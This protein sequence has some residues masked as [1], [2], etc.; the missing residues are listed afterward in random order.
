MLPPPRSIAT[1]WRTGRSWTAPRKP[2]IAS[3][4][5]S[6]T[7][8]GTPAS[9]ASA[10]GIA[11]RASRTADVATAI[12]RSAPAPSAIARKSRRASRVRSI[13]SG[14]SR[15]SSRNSRPR[16]RG[17]RASS[18]TSRCSPGRS[19]NT[20][21]RAEFE[22]TSTTANGRSSARELVRPCTSG[23]S[24]TRPERPE[25]IGRPRADG[26]AGSRM[27]PDAM[28]TLFLIRHGLTAV[29]GSRLY[30]RTQ[31]HPSRRA[32]PPTGGR[33]RRAVRGR[34]AQRDL[35]E[36]AGTLHRD[37]GATR[38]GP[39]ARDPHLGCADRDGRRRL[40]G[41]N[42]PSLRRTKLWDTVQ[43]SPSRFHFPSGESFVD[44]EARLLDEIE[45]VVARHPRGRV[46][47]GTHGDLV[48]MLSPTTRAPTW[49]SSNE[50]R[51]DPASVSRRASR[52]RD[53]PHPARERHREPSSVRSG[54]PRRRPGT[55]P[56]RAGRDGRGRKLRG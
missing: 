14:P 48:G 51:V 18:R 7:S 52:R 50:S 39:R 20:I 32:R 5:P 44:A 23:C 29:T 35:L 6:M 40:D 9:R 2:N 55:P 4:F 56:L 30:G 41:P 15:S 46:V 26:E 16:R 22:P 34:S 17:A 11:V 42:P 49:T 3:V 54:P 36:P 53:P 37:P 47:V 31:G 45:R 43:R 12:M 27:L 25:T 10:R 38:D 33:T 13:A 1:P 28:T 19:R 24:H 21:I 8:R